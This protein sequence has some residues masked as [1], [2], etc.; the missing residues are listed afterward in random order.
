MAP[1]ARRAALCASQRSRLQWTVVEEIVERSI[2]LRIQAGRAFSATLR[3][4]SLKLRGVCAADIGDL[5][6]LL[7]SGSGVR[8]ASGVVLAGDSYHNRKDRASGL[9]GPNIPGDRPWRKRCEWGPTDWPVGHAPGCPLFFEQF[10]QAI[11][12][13]RAI[14]RF[15]QQ[16]ADPR[17]SIVLL[18]LARYAPLCVTIPFPED[19][20]HFGEECVAPAALLPFKPGRW[21]R[22]RGG[23]RTFSRPGRQRPLGAG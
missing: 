22:L 21:T 23:W 1:P 16:F 15:H 14:T 4:G 2:S 10:F 7:W 8:R 19:S 20:S 3:L 13:K 6:R 12:A 18:Y 17:F 9:N 11:F 5:H